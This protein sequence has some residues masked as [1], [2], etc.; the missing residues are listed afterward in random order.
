MSFDVPAQ[1]KGLAPGHLSLG[2]ISLPGP[3]VRQTAI[4]AETMP[5]VRRI[6]LMLNC[7]VSG[8]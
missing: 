7:I 6:V 5:R 3:L 4:A 1:A 8:W 2:P